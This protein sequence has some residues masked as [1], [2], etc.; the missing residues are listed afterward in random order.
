MVGGCDSI[1]THVNVVCGFGGDLFW[2]L[3]LILVEG[4]GKSNFSKSE[5]C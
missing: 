2:A 3:V 1:E 4:R 5:T